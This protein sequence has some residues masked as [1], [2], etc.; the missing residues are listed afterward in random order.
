[1]I[2]API[3]GLHRLIGPTVAA[4]LGEEARR[5]VFA[6]VVAEHEAILFLMRMLRGVQR[7]SHFVRVAAMLTCAEHLQDRLTRERCAARHIDEPTKHPGTSF[8]EPGQHGARLGMA[9]QDHVLHAGVFQVGD[10][11]GGDVVDPHSGC[12]P[13]ALRA[14][15]GDIEREYVAAPAA[16]LLMKR[17]DLSSQTQPPCPP[18]CRNANEGVISPR[19]AS[20]AAISDLSHITSLRFVPPAAASSTATHPSSRTGHPCSPG[21]HPARHRGGAGP[22][23]VVFLA[24]VRGLVPRAPSRRR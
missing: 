9:D 7:P 24:T 8:S 17:R 12:V 1:M 2:V 22:A 16:R 14:A 11:F 5:C 21:R 3:R 20:T 4:Q 13:A 19:A 18:P 15:T 23:A 10:Q 6:H